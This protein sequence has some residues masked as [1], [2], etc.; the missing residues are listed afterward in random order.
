MP[1]LQVVAPVRFTWAC[2]P[3]VSAKVTKSSWPIPTVATAA[4]LALEM[5]GFSGYSAGQLVF[6]PEEVEA[7]ITPKTKAI[8]AVHLY[9][10]LCD[11]EALLAIGQ[12]WHSYN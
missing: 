7:A 2:M 6:D 9:G 4:P 10:N 3:W 5:T 11:M 8:V 12:Q 1:S